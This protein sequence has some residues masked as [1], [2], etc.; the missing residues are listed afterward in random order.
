MVHLG[1]RIDPFDGATDTSGVVFAAPGARSGICSKS[2][3]V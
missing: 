2:V 3:S 1:R